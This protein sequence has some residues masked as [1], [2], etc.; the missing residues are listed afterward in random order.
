M[1]ENKKHVFWQALFVT[2]LLFLMGFVFGVYIEQLRSDNLSTSFYQSEVSLYDS[3][4]LG[5]ITSDSSASCDDLKKISI[6]FAD[7]VYNEAKELE[8][9]DDKNKLTD[10][11][12][13]IHKKY[14]L[15]RTLLWM[16]VIDIEKKCGAINNV[17]YLYQ[18]NTDD[19]V[20]KSQQVV[21]GRL[22]SDLKTKESD[23]LILIPI[24]VDQNI[25]SLNYLI[26]KYGIKNYPAVL[27]N[28]KDILYQ[29]KT[30]EEIENYLK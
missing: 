21:W 28:E 22:L 25:E 18:Y 15:L 19:V 11:I 3:L 23:K 14:D 30:I 20:V 27:I 8:K 16:N 17:V 9:Y 13:T 24:A 10:S 1:F 5:K 6:N 4:A 7:K 29:P 26:N 12:K 2:V